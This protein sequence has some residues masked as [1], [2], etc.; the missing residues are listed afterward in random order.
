MEKFE[1][2]FSYTEETEMKAASQN[3][4]SVSD[5]LECLEGATKEIRNKGLE[6][7][8]LQIL[9]HSSEPS[10]FLI[11]IKST[12]KQ[13]LDQGG[14]SILIHHL[15]FISSSLEEYRDLETEKE[16]RVLLNILYSL[17]LFHPSDEV[18]SELLQNTSN[19]E[20]FIFSMIHISTELSYIPIKKIC[21]LFHQYLKIILDSP[22]KHKFIKNSL[23]QDLPRCRIQG[24]AVES[25]YVRL[26]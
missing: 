7:L 19:L 13:I 14:L 15:S 26:N 6:S 23:K 25:F 8:Y 2:F 20:D 17:F 10:L 22:S 5:M 1:L 3:L 4:E 21:L 18:Q 24:S 12:V 16:L 9:K 11:S